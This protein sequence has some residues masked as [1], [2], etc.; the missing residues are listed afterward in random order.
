MGWLDD[1]S[2]R[3]GIEA[4]I[5]GHTGSVCVSYGFVDP[6]WAMSMREKLWGRYISVPSV[7]S[8]KQ[9]IFIPV[10]CGVHW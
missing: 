5:S 7:F 4:A 2:V 3:M 9:V 6:L 1:E 10:G 8:L